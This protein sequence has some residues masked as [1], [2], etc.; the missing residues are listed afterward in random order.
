MPRLSAQF[1]AQRPKGKPFFFWF[2]SHQPHRS[3]PKDEGVKAGKRPEQVDR[4][5]GFWPDNETIRKDM[6]DYAVEV[7]KFDTQLGQVLKV[8]EESGEADNTLVIVTS[9]NGMPFPR[10]KGHTYELAT[11]MP[12]AMAWKN[13]LK[14]PGRKAADL[15][16]FIDLAPTFL[17]VAGVDPAKSG[18]APITG[19]SLTDII[20][21]D[22]E[23]NRKFV[24]VGRERNDWGRPMLQAYPTRGIV[25]GHHLLLVNMEPDRWPCCNPEADYPDTDASPSKSFIAAAR[26]KPELHKYWNYCFGKRP[27]EEFFD[28][29]SDP[30]CI[31]NLAADPAAK[32]RKDQMRKRLFDLLKAQQDPRVLGN[33]EVFDRYPPSN[34]EWIGKFER[35]IAPKIKP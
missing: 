1:L 31:K 17:D 10:V 13:G 15:V 4:V 16:S 3:Y 32:E 18:M 34:K 6:L 7:E 33:G 9:D 5:P 2:G 30:D 8:L 28:L 23:R 19:K 11:H 25:E 20:R 22:K 26:D 12:M 27:A 29:T 24:L 21:D 14:N 35:E